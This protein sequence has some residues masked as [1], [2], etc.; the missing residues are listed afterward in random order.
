MKRCWIGAGFLLVL[1]LFS[2]GVSWAM[3]EIHQPIE[4]DLNRAAELALLGDWKRSQRL[5]L[6]ARDQWE[7]YAHVRACFADH[8]PTEEVD[9]GFRALEVY[10]LAREKADFAAQ[11][12]ALARKTA[13]MGEA[14]GLSWW[15]VL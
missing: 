14:H 15:N 4:E 13:A 11:A 6:R 8:T 5:F 3:E 2:L 1:L 10:A 7:D 9:A 12:R